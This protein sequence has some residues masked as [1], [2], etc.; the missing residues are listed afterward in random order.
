MGT[1]LR[2]LGVPHVTNAGVERLL[3]TNRAACLLAFMAT[4]A[5]WVRRDELMLLFWPDSDDAAARHALRQ[6]LYRARS[7]PWS[8]GI[9]QRDDRL[10]WLVDS[11]VRRFLDLD[12]SGDWAG[13]AAAYGGPFLDGLDV[14]EAAG[15]DAW[16]D[17]LRE[18]L[19]TRSLA[20]SL[21]AAAAHEL[22][23]DYAGAI[24]TLRSAHERDPLHDEVLQA[25]LRCLALAGERAAAEAAYTHYEAA[26]ATQLDARPSAETRALM[27]RLRRGDVVEGR[28]HNL[29][30]QTTSFVGREAE[31]DALTRR[32]NRA[33]C[34]LITLVGPGG[35][36]KTRLA[37][38]SAANHVGA[39]RNGV[40]FVP[41]SD[42]DRVQGVAVA[43]AEALGLGLG[44]RDEPWAALAQRLCDRE[45]LLVLDGMEHVRDA[46]GRL[47]NLLTRAPRLQALVTSREPLDLSLAWE[48]HLEGLELPDSDDATDEVASLRLFEDA[49]QRVAPGFNLRDGDLR[50]AARVCRLVA[51]MP[52]AIELAASWARLLTPDD[53]AREIAHDLDF[54]SGTDADRPARHHGLRRVFDASWIRMRE[55][56]QAALVRTA[57]FAGAVDA[58]AL[59]AVADARLATVLALTKRSLLVRT[60]DHRFA[61][62]PLVR[63]YVRE[64][65]ATRD[66]LA[67][68]LSA[69]HLRYFAARVAA[70]TYERD[71]GELVAH[72]NRDLVEVRRAWRY[73]I[74]RA[75]WDA[76]QSMLAN[77]S[78]AH[79]LSARSDRYLEWLDEALLAIARDGRTSADDTLRARLRARRA[80]CLHRL[81][82]LA[83]AEFEIDTSLPLLTDTDAERCSALRVRGNIAYQRADLAAA[84]AA[85]DAALA[86][87]TSVGDDRL[88][89][90]CH[91]NLGLVAKVMGRFEDAL[92]HLDLAL[93]LAR[94][95]DDGICAQVLNNLA[96]VHSRRGDHRRAEALLLESIAIKRRIGDHRGLT[97]TYANLGNL[98]A[99]RN[100]VAAEHD[101][102]ESLRVATIIADQ[103]GV[104]R[105][106]TNLAELAYRNGDLAR[107]IEHLTLS[108]E[109]KRLNGEQGG[110]I[111]AYARLVSWSLAAGEVAAA[112]S[113]A[114]D[115]WRYARRVGRDDLI[116]PLREACLPLGLAEAPSSA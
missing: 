58:D 39:Y 63:Q 52:L 29:P 12:A 41:L 28:P 18:D 16:R 71:A 2:L 62:H 66:G 61:M 10:R 68:A 74:E 45:L 23:R 4:R 69:R 76:L 55:T 9:E 35:I 75:E 77:L 116:A 53:I 94:R 54:L 15:F 56:E 27:E 44:A 97:S 91:N 57:V 107:A 32:L 13:A 6:L 105:A 24:A 37:L 25:L 30:S 17:L 22:R 81:G 38:E 99:H 1:T 109:R 90:G 20:A 111:E 89:A 51:G 84:V 80:G 110:A 47:A 85:F 40:F 60:A 64:R 113:W 78:L 46:A 26:V 8:G 114:E 14:L 115:G 73:A 86:T 108:V 102:R 87:A 3:P 106:H 100:D 104:A 5:D 95:S 65:L 79:D 82:R 88:I 42:V 93:V 33:G 43:I 11:D 96:T 70:W 92:E 21:K 98:R 101:H 83:E 7:Y 19:H 59:E 67:D 72:L 112:R 50:G 36:G 49:A 48:L 34:R 103:V 31:L